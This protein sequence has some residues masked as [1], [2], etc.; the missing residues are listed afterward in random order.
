MLV[1][2]KVR[3][4]RSEAGRAVREEVSVACVRLGMRWLDAD[5]LGWRGCHGDDVGRAERLLSYLERFPRGRHN[6]EAAE[7]LEIMADRLAGDA[8]GGLRARLRAVR[9]PQL[10]PIARDTWG[11]PRAVRPS[12]P[13]ARPAIPLVRAAS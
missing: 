5:E 11:G 3:S 2:P 1:V 12:R 9:Q 4:E 8:Q 13:V 7:A 6:R 10:G